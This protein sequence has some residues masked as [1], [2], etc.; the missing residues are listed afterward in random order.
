VSRVCCNSTILSLL[1][2]LVTQRSESSPPTAFRSL[3]LS[4]YII[5]LLSGTNAGHDIP[6]SDLARDPV[7]KR[8]HL[9]HK[10]YSRVPR[11]VFVSSIVACTH[12][13]RDPSSRPNGTTMSQHSTDSP[14]QENKRLAAY[15]AGRPPLVP[16]QMGKC[17]AVVMAY[18]GWSGGTSGGH[19]GYVNMSFP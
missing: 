18:G 15:C 3:T 19:V 16:L 12:S 4:V 11:T 6:S 2:T 1:L 17:G 5:P 13:F 8:S 10:R 7:A 14:I 9:R